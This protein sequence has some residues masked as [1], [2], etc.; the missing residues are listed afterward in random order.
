M[1]LAEQWSEK[2]KSVRKY[3]KNA[4]SGENYAESQQMAVPGVVP[5]GLRHWLDDTCSYLIC[6]Y[7]AAC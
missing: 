1:D 3:K 2:A 4:A 7:R 6:T 5:T